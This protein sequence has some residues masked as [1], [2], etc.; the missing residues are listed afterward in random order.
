MK[1][2]SIQRQ[3]G[4]FL[5]CSLAITFLLAACDGDSITGGGGGG[6]ACTVANCFG[7]GSTGGG[8]SQNPNLS[9]SAV[10]GDGENT[11]TFALSSGNADSFNIYWSTSPDTT[12][13]TWNKIE[14]ATSPFLHENLSNGVPRFYG[15]TAVSGGSESDPS[16]VVGAMPGKWTQLDQVTVIDPPARDSHTAVYNPTTDRMIVFGGKTQSATLQDL[17]VLSNASGA[18]AGN[19]T[20]TPP[21]VSSPPPI[22]ASHTAVYDK[23]TNKMIVFAGSGSTDGTSLLRNDLWSLSDADGSG[24]PSW[25]LPPFNGSPPSTRWGH[26]AVY[27]EQADIMI[28]FGGAQTGVAIFDDVWVL[29]DATQ[30]IPTWRQISMPATGG[31][32]ARCCMAVGYDSTNR[33]MIIFGGFG[34]FGQ[35]GATLF[36]DLWTLTFDAT[37]QTA[38][39]K[40]LTPSG[41]TAPSARCCAASFWDGSKFLLFGGGTFNNSSDDKIYAFVLQDDT[42]ATA[43]GAS[44]GPPARTFPTAVPAGH[45]LLFGGTE[46]FTPFNDLWRLE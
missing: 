17:W 33:R 21:N 22:R 42:F 2:V 29:E 31:P 46:E 14:G 13:P 27:D 38:T 5:L 11:L 19:P 35:S 32:S 7:G 34:G 30:F 26:A 8:G 12:T 25:Q 28:V 23:Q 4:L 39:W 20:W 41:G 16:A 6:G 37:F 36:G 45:F 10:P 24:S 44:G 40:E 18:S 1:E 43:D 9:I 15:V 3:I